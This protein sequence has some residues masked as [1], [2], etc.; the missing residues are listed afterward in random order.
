MVGASDPWYVTGAA[1]FTCT[2]AFVAV[3][4]MNNACSASSTVQPFHAGLTNHMAL[5]AGKGEGV[6]TSGHGD[7]MGKAGGWG[8]AALGNPSYSV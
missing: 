4:A 3:L 1:P 6:R 5:W 8:Q 7:G 2:T